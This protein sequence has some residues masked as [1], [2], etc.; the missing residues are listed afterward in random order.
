M[1]ADP[2]ERERL[3]QLEADVAEPT[4]DV[5]RRGGTF[6]SFRFRGFSLF[7]AGAFVSNTGSWMQNYA[8]AIVVYGLRHSEFDSGMVNFVSGIPV[9]FLALP[10]GALADKIDKRRLLIVSQ[11][12][13]LL[14]ASALAL[15]YTSGHLTP[16]NAI[17]SL[18]WIGGLGLLG[19][20]MSALTFPHG[21]RCFPTSSR[22]SRC[23]T[24]SH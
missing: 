21:S 19:G 4:G 14:Q 9:L 18:M 7:W 12:V 17:P 3:E 5:V 6:E 13:M 10:A 20:V 16:S 1:S 15:L 24:R 23:S 8:L 11:F 22:G 2:D